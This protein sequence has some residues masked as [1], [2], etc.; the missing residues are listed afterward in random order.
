MKTN[1]R[2]SSTTLLVLA[3][4]VA[5]A[6]GPGARAQSAAAPLP[7]S[8]PRELVEALLRPIYGFYSSSNTAGFSV[9]KIPASVAPFLFVP[10]NA[11]ILGGVES[12]NSTVAI[13]SVRMSPEQ[14][15]T[16]FLREQP[17]LGWALPSAGAD[18]RGWGFMPAPGMNP[19]SAGYQYCHIGQSLSISPSVT[20]D[21]WTQVTATV[22]NYSGTCNGQRPTFANRPTTPPGLPSVFNPEDGEMNRPSCFSNEA[23]VGISN[24]SAERLQTKLTP[25]QLIDYFA[26]QLAD[27][28][29]KSTSDVPAARRSWT[30][31][32]SGGTLREVTITILPGQAVNVPSCHDL[33][34]QVR[35]V[36]PIR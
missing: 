33:T 18:P 22:S 34:M 8:L 16:S 29:W 30:R 9:G 35:L 2:Q 20:S 6:S 1:I 28:G 13:Y 4:I 24:T 32:D 36:R 14:L 23:V 27:S 10:P 17:K 3:L 31:P 25:A 21:G 26:R 7:D 12:Q 19:A 15:R 5:P 11:R